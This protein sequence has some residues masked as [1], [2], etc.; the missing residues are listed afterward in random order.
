MVAIPIGPVGFLIIQRSISVGSV[1]GVA[2]GFGA[3][4]ADGLFG[5]LAALGLVALLGQ[6]EASRHFIRPLGSLAL[7]G[8]GLYF[9]FHKSVELDTEDVLSPRYLRHHLWDLVSTFF[10][11]LINPATIV[12]FAALFTGSDLIPDDPKK[13]DYLV[14][15]LGVFS[16]SLCW[17]L[18]LVVA[19]KPLKRLLSAKVQRR[20]FQTIGLVLV[21]V[22][23]FTFVPRLATT[24]D[25]LKTVVK[26]PSP[27]YKGGD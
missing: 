18:L 22:A 7:M 11:A 26:Y 23:L 3:A 4:M 25:K 15:A 16:G 10:L 13:I 21:T 14:I 24:I 6:L 12:A 17:W 2:S 9:Y 19:A 5:F 20:I 8:V 27:P 1:R